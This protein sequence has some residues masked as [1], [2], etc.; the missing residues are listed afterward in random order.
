MLKLSESEFFIGTHQYIEREFNAFLDFIEFMCCRRCWR[1]THDLGVRKPYHHHGGI[2]HNLSKVN[3]SKEEYAMWLN[4][5][6]HGFC[7]GLM[8]AFIMFL[9]ADRA[10]C[11]AEVGHFGEDSYLKGEPIRKTPKVEAAFIAG[12]F[13]DF[14]KT[15]GQP[16]DHDT[17]L[18]ERFDFFDDAVYRHSNPQ[19]DDL[20][21]PLVKADRLELMRYTDY[22]D[23]CDIGMLDQNVI[24]QWRITHFY[25]FIRPAISKIIED[26][27]AIWVSHVIEETLDTS[28]D[29]YPDLHWI[30]HDPSMPETADI[31]Q[32]FS[33]NIGKIPIIRCHKHAIDVLLNKPKHVRSIS[34]FISL[35]RLLKLGGDVCSYPIS[36]WGRDHPFVNKKSVALPI[37]EWFFVYSRIIDTKLI[38]YRKCGGLIGYHTFNRLHTVIEDLLCQI[39]AIS[40]R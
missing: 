7:H 34:G 2:M 26:L 39:Q 18:R 19:P 8:V 17:K 1:K 20:N 30:A 11:Y 15:I 6:E 12:L 33:V 9:L 23:W 40:V 37:N 25:N 31:G 28:S 32:Y 5:L 3:M 4:D 24:K 13:H 10:K 38:N 22:K 35:N 21:N 36:T 16:V 29:V 27:N 14:Q